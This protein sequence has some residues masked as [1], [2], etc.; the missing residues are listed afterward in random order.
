MVDKFPPGVPLQVLNASPAPED[1]G[2]LQDILGGEREERSHFQGSGL[3]CG[4]AALGGVTQPGSSTAPLHL[5]LFL[6]ATPARAD[7][8]DRTKP[9]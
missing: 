7:S 9:N 2:L 4:E 6:K 8:Q 3:Y 5:A 1:L